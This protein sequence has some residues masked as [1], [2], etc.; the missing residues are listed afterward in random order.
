MRQ[1]RR[2]AHPVNPRVALDGALSDD[3]AGASDGLLEL[4]WLRTPR[5][6]RLR[7][8]LDQYPR[9][10]NAAGYTIRPARSGCIRGAA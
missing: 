10:S 2:P 4:Q 1:T 8:R 6:P 7:E 9:A 5:L 3:S